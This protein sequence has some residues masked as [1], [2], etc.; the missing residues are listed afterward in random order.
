[1]RRHES[2]KKGKG[3]RG[4]NGKISNEREIREKMHLTEGVGLEGERKSGKEWKRE[5]ERKTDREEKSEEKEEGEGGKREKER[6][7]NTPPHSFIINWN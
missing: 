4:E 5:E 1:M 2:E 3:K 6:K 7:K